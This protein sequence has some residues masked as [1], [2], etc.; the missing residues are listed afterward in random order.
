MEY[1][2][3]YIRVK[4]RNFGFS[5]SVNNEKPIILVIFTKDLSDTVACDFFALLAC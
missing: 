2:L 3:L 1:Y 5:V 4:N